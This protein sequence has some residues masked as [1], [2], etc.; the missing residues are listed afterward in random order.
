MKKTIKFFA[1]MAV[2]GAMVFTGCKKDDEETTEAVKTETLQITFAGHVVPMGW[3]DATFNG[4]RATIEAATAHMS[5]GSLE[6]FTLPYARLE[7]TKNAHDEG[8][9]YNAYY[10][11]HRNR[12]YDNTCEWAYDDEGPQSFQ[13]NGFDATALTF[14]S[15]IASMTMYDYYAQEMNEDVIG[16]EI[17]TATATN[18]TLT[19]TDAKKVRNYSFND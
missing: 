3:F 16:E 14:E 12:I 11:E 2:A 4:Q 17:M 18:I 8:E 7:F 6:N 13:L 10:C 5:K 19:R 9:I 1:L 15:A